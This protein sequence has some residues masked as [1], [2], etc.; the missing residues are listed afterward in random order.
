MIGQ[1]RK[2]ELWRE[3]RWKERLR[4]LLENIGELTSNPQS[5][6]STLVL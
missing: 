3:D 1:V 4:G 2:F 5:V 6:V